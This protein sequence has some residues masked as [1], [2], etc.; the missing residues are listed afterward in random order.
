M[1]FEDSLELNKSQVVSVDT[2][3][4][5]DVS[6]SLEDA[7][8]AGLAILT[9]T[10]Y[11]TQILTG[12]PVE[13]AVVFVFDAT[14]NVV[15]F[16]K[17][18]SLGV[19]TVSGLTNSTAYTAVAVKDGYT[20]TAPSSFTAS[21]LIVTIMN[22]AIIPNTD[23]NLNTVYGIIKDAADA[24]ISGV[25]VILSDSSTNDVISTT[26]TIDDGEYVLYNIPTGS[27]IIKTVKNGYYG[28]TSNTIALTTSQNHSENVTMEAVSDPNNGVISGIITDSESQVVTN[29][30]VGLYSIT[31]DNEPET[32]IRYTF[33][34]SN[35][36]YAFGDVVPGSYIVKA[37]L[38][39]EST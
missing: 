16:A 4:S 12:T 33:T 1:E 32:L 5:A 8:A 18:N 38:S 13:D 36:R 19:Y 35:G 39:T 9:G 30:F 28:T 34:N 24:A 6:L 17:T 7:P 22:F 2:Q 21:I 27:Y 3:G 15:S 14:G 26:G 37:K 11:D 23:F 20:A 25:T 10:V 29:A 31:V